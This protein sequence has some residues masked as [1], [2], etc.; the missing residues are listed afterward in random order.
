MQSALEWLAV[1][2]ANWRHP[3]GPDSHIKDNSKDL[4]KHPVT[5]VSYNDA[6]EYCSWANM[7]LP[8]EIEWEFAARGT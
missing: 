6:F 3:H 2:Q 1:K 4:Q 5:Q 7:Q 8:T